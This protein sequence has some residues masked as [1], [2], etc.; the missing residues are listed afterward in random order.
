MYF[1]GIPDSH[2]SSDEKLLIFT[3]ADVGY[4]IDKSFYNVEFLKK[5]NTND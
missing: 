1:G 5:F 3:I 2:F 4:T